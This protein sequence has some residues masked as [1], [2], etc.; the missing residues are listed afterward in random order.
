MK[1]NG[2]RYWKE[3]KNP[4]VGKFAASKL[5][6]P[7]LM[8]DEFRKQYSVCVELNNHVGCKQENSINSSAEQIPSSGTQTKD[9]RAT[10][11]QT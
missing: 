11:Y 4:Y 10:L 8:L 5:S 2:Q 3:S 6:I 7:I 9:T 1:K